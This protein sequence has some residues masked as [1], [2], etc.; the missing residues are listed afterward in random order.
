LTNYL[1]IHFRHC[2]V[3]PSPSDPTIS[4]ATAVTG[5]SVVTPVGSPAPNSQGRSGTPSSA[6]SGTSFSLI[7]CQQKVEAIRSSRDSYKQLY[8]NQAM[9][10]GRLYNKKL[11]FVN[12][13]E[14]IAKE[15]DLKDEQIK[16]TEVQRAKSFKIM[17][18]KDKALEWAQKN[19]LKYESLLVDESMYFDDDVDEASLVSFASTVESQKK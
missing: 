3:P 9:E 14:R 11:A 8:A 19:V 1:H 18:A 12:E 13:A 7:Q 15:I 16:S 5:T 4:G 2:P 10:I 6:I 17:M